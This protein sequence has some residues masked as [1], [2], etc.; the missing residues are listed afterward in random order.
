MLN[1]HS[2]WWHSNPV[3]WPPIF[4][5]LCNSPLRNY[6][7][8]SL[9]LTCRNSLE[10]IPGYLSDLGEEVPADIKQK[11]YYEGAFYSDGQQWEA[12]HKQCEM[13]RYTIQYS[14]SVL[15]FF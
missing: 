15:S 14:I 8:Q 5:Y 7:T 3:F 10:V 2:R 13:C 12:S 4:T 1:T 11:C 9:F 6:L